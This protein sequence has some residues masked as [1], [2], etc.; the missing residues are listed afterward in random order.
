MTSDADFPA[1]PWD[2]NP[3][4]QLDENRFDYF[5]TEEPTIPCS[6]CDGKG[7]WPLAGPCTDCLGAGEI[8]AQ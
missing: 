2:D 8:P 7:G 3:P 6:T 1:Q 5:I 4:F